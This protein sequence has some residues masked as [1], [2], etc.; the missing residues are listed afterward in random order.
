MSLRPYLKFR[1]ILL[2]G[3]INQGS[4]KTIAVLAA[5]L[6]LCAGAI[7]TGAEDEFGLWLQPEGLNYVGIPALKQLDPNLNGEGIRF[8]VVCRS[9]TYIDGE[10]QND[11]RPNAEHNCF[12]PE[13]LSF[14]DEGKLPAGISPHSTAICSILLG[15]DSNGVNSQLG[16]FYYQGVT[17][18][19]QA[20]VYEFWHFLINNVFGNIRPEADVLTAS[21]GNHFE[22]WWTRGIESMIEHHGLIVVAGIGNGSDV[23]QPPLYPAAGANAIGVGVVDSV[24]TEDLATTLRHFALA[25]PEHSSFGP[26]SD[27]RCKPDILAV[28]NC[29]VADA[30]E[31]DNYKPTGSWSSFSTPVVA[32]TL[33]LLVQKARQDT[34]LNNAL[35]PNGGNCVMKAILMNSARKLP[36]WHKGRLEKDDDHEVPLDYIQGAGVLSAPAAYNQLVAGQNGPGSVSQTG[37]D[38]N[39]LNK[40]EEPG[41]TYKITV[42]E[43]A[44]KIIAATAAWNKHY[45]DV[46]PFEPEP[47]KDAN[48]RLEIW[49]LDAED[50][51]NDYL[52]DYSDSNCDNV[53][54]IFSSADANHTDYEIVISY[55]SDVDPNTSQRYGLAWNVS[56]KQAEEEILWYD[57]NADGLVDEA[58]FVILADNLI[59][60]IKSPEDYLLGDINTDGKIDFNDVQILLEHKG[61]TASWHK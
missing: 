57:L 2:L 29:L 17:P 12:Q 16:E 3:L 46:Y 1:R 35:D 31:R 45:S 42:A 26:T 13:Q 60:S 20:D 53:E 18:S 58:D 27:G 52:L 23:H 15:E 54:H 56:D 48:L 61:N 43:P 59:T 8:A 25:Y 36:Y 21:M 22:D 10:P 33:G 4:F 44:N 30:N 6:L 47:E 38:L 7:A 39:T 55:S 24:N 40:N 51:N 34:D 11:Y 32:G 19:A 5:A 9:I 49:A 28:G 50:A 37:W 14:K 41:N